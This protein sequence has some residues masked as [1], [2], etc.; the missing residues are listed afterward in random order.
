MSEGAMFIGAAA[1]AL[2][3]PESRLRRLCREG[4]ISPPLAGRTRLFPSDRIEEF[5]QAIR[6][7][8][9]AKISRATVGGAV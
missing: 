2:G 1:V 8:N 7:H 9:A 5:R 4:V 6:K 3:V